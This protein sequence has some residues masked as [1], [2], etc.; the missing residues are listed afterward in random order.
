MEP[1]GEFFMGRS[2]VMVIEDH[3]EQSQEMAETIK[4]LKE[5]RQ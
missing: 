3:G 1:M 5:V 2:T 4:M